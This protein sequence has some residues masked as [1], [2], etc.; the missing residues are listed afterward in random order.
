VPGAIGGLL[1]GFYFSG[2]YVLE[3]IASP[4]HNRELGLLELLQ[5]IEIVAIFVLALLGW[6]RAV[7]GIERAAF[8]SVM[9]LSFMV[10]GE[11]LDWGYHI[12]YTLTGTQVWQSDS[13]HSSLHSS[14][15]HTTDTTRLIKRVTDIGL[16]CLFVLLPLFARNTR[17]EWLRYFTPA[18]LSIAT[19]LCALVI[20]RTAHFL[21]HDLMLNRDGGLHN[22]ISEFREFFTYYVALLY[23]YELVVRRQSPAARSRAQVGVPGA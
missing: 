6:R 17:N 20:A 23:M 22:N 10:L 16:V 7:T 14:L 12:V 8:A 18:R 3:V 11:E 2:I 21:E 4:R 19:L 5:N 1:V 9:V 15:H 13:L